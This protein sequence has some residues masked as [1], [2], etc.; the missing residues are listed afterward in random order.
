MIEQV[1]SGWKDGMSQGDMR[2]QQEFKCY[3]LSR[4]KKMMEFIY[5]YKNKIDYV[6]FV[7]CDG[8]EI[9]RLEN[10]PYLLSLLPLDF[11]IYPL[12]AGKIASVH[13]ISVPGVPPKEE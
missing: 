2:E 4:D 10:I 12:V 7:Y 11:H 13:N 9:I 5:Q 8:F 1:Y 6:I 3:R